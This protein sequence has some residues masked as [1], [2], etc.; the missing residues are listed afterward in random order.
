MLV[1]LSFRLIDN[2][3]INDDNNKKNYSTS[4]NNH[5][6]NYK[7]D[8]LA[9]ASGIELTARRNQREKNGIH[10]SPLK[11]A[12]THGKPLDPTGSQANPHVKPLDL[13]GT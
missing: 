4:S 7:H 12:G 9:R 5:D 1:R 3:K 2:S 13:T 8:T 10:G 11:P 6:D